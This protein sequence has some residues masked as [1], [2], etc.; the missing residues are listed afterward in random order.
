MMR[1]YLGIGGYVR[2]REQNELTWGVKAQNEQNRV[3]NEA[4]FLRVHIASIARS[5]VLTCTVSTQVVCVTTPI[6]SRKSST[7]NIHLLR[8]IGG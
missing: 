8:T 4:L 7:D 5:T 3:L 6:L 2:S 1:F